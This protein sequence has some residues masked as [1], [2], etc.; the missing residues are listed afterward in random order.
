METYRMNIVYKKLSELKPYEKNPRKNDKAVKYVAESIKQFGFKVPII[1][2]NKGVIVAGHTRYKAATELKMEEVPCIVADDLNPN[3]IK[4]FRL[5]D[6]RV[7]ELSEWDFEL[8]DEELAKLED[9]FNLNELGFEEFLKV[10][11]E[12]D[13]VDD[14]FDED[15]FAS[16]EIISKKGDIYILG[17]HR[18]M[19]GDSCVQ[20]DVDQL[21]PEN[22]FIAAAFTDPPWN[23]D[24]G[25]TSHPSWRKRS[26]M[27]DK[28]SG[29]DFN[30][31]LTHAF[32]KIQPHLLP[33]AMFYVVMSAQEWGNIMDVMSTYNYHWSSTIIWAKDSLVLSR[34]DYH[35]QYEPIWYGWYEG[36]SKN[37]AARI[38]P[39]EDRT[40][41]DLWNIPRP[42]VSELHP[43][44]KPMELVVRAIKNSSHE[45]DNVWDGFGGSGTTLIAAEQTNRNCYMMELDPHYVDVIAKRYI[46]FV[47]SAKDCYLIRKG[48][49][50]ELP[51]ELVDGLLDPFPNIE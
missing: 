45:K 24:Y 20:V 41:S 3:Q 38:C 4:A 2:D 5:A 34:K 29:E 10:D 33:G 31:F 22:T 26:I 51:H 36:D 6:N 50:L 40:Q 49:K 14:E 9:E 25:G 43:T 46:K 30:Q 42:K 21:I 13:I 47:G 12:E 1:I 11:E 8:L 7:A 37:P 32:E 23:V 18:L 27:N 35:T 44:T 17:R 19:C 15:E 28:M 39:L 48:E 16:D